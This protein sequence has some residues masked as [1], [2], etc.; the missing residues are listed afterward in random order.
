[1]ADETVSTPDAIS[2]PPEPTGGTLV[3]PRAE[4]TDEQLAMQKERR[5]RQATK[6][7][8]QGF[9]QYEIAERIGVSQ[10]I[11][12]KYLAQ[13]RAGWEMDRKRDA[14]AL[15]SRELARL[16]LAESRYW[17]AW[18]KS[19][20]K[21]VRVTVEKGSVDGKP[22]E[23][24]IE[25]TEDSPG[26]PRFLAG[27]LECIRMRCKLLGLEAP[28]QSVVTVVPVKVVAGLDLDAV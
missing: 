24:R 5:V 22:T 20:G 19:G 17:E 21:L 18:E 1:M 16:D 6:L 15:V 10:P 2:V 26:D 13:V 11:V 4:Y 25:V 3:I 23:R 8:L 9:T 14:K 12:S 27:V 7:Y 28:K